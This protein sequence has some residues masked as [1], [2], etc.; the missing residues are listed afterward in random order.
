VERGRFRGSQKGG[1]SFLTSR[2]FT[3]SYTH[4]AASNRTGF[5]DPES[6]SL[7]L[8]L[9]IHRP[10]EPGHRLWLILTGRIWGATTIRFSGPDDQRG[11][12]TS[13]FV[14]NLANLRRL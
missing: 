6:G 13:I 14:L 7:V 4:H 2:N 9:V 10:V 8:L 5:T 12:R 3:N 11:T 1:P